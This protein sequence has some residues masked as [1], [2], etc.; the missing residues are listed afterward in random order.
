MRQGHQ[1]K[2]GRGR[3][4]KNSN[5]L[6]R[7]YESNGPDV[8]IRGSASHIAEKYASLARDSHSSGDPV[9]AENYWQHAE[10]YYRIIQAAEAQAQAK[11]QNTT[12]GNN[13]GQRHQ[14]GDGRGNQP[15]NRNGN[16]AHGV[17]GDGQEEVQSAAPDAADEVS[18]IADT[19]PEKKPSRPARNGTNGKAT[20]NKAADQSAA[21]DGSAEKKPSKKAGDKSPE[22]NAPPEDVNA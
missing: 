12:A 16:A 2:R 11:S 3:S 22:K 20:V 1:N 17:N 9:S 10:H 6:S 14:Q 15:R 19:T 18:I 5:P 7:N 21:G 8:K 4:R 13:A